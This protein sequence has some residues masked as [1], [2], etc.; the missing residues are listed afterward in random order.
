MSASKRN[1]AH[2]GFR[3]VMGAS[4]G[5]NIRACRIAAMFA[6]AVPRALK[7]LPVRPNTRRAGG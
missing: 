5:M 3:R 2:H 1:T 6:H 4:D 7:A